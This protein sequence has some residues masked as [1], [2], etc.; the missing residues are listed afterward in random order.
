MDRFPLETSADLA[1]Q[2]ALNSAL[3]RNEDGSPCIPEKQPERCF[4]CGRKGGQPFLMIADE[5][6]CSRCFED[7]TPEEFHRYLIDAGVR[8]PASALEA[9]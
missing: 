7:F 5:L 2:A 6:H 1:H 4:Y 8:T 3:N 9:A